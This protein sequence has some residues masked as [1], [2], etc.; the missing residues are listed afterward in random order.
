MPA[1]RVIVSRWGY[2]K[3][4]PDCDAACQIQ[5]ASAHRPDGLLGNAARLRKGSV[6]SN[7]VHIPEIIPDIYYVR[8]KW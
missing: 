7:E 1:L 4:G 8:V 5:I 6:M 3:L 2:K